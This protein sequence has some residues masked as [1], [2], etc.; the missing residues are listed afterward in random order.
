MTLQKYLEYHWKRTKNARKT[1]GFGSQFEDIHIWKNLFM[2][3]YYQERCQELENLLTRVQVH[4]GHCTNKLMKDIRE[5]LE[6][7]DVNE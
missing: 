4:E 6:E 1:I 3:Y 7:R 2:R 5:K